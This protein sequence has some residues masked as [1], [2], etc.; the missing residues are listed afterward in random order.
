MQPSLNYL[1]NKER[2]N[3]RLNLITYCHI[4][5]VNCKDRQDSKGIG[6]T[7]R[8]SFNQ[9]GKQNAPVLITLV[10]DDDEDSDVEFPL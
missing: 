7:K 3:I 4:R 10:V 2:E 1:I 5:G 9:K 6:N 8:A